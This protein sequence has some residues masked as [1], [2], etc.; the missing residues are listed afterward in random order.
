MCLAAT[1]K[2]IALLMTVKLLSR[3]LPMRYLL[4]LL[5]LIFPAFT[6]AQEL[7]T[8][9][10]GEVAD[11]EKINQN[12]E[13]LNLRLE[14]FESQLNSEEINVDCSNNPK[15]LSEVQDQINSGGSI[16][17]VTL[18]GA[19]DLSYLSIN[20]GRVS[21]SGGRSEGH[22]DEQQAVISQ[23]V[24]SS[25]ALMGVSS[26][27]YL[28]FDCLT[29]QGDYFLLVAS[30][31]GTMVM[32]KGVESVNAETFRVDVMSGGVLYSGYPPKIDSLRA[33]QGT[34]KLR[35]TRQPIDIGGL[36]MNQSN[37]LCEYCN[38]S[39]SITSLSGGSRATYSIADPSKFGSGYVQSPRLFVNNLY[40]KGSI[41]DITTPDYV[42]TNGEPIL[43]EAD[44]YGITAWANSTITI[45][46][47]HGDSE[48]HNIQFANMSLS[49]GSVAVVENCDWP[50]ANSVAFHDSAELYFVRAGGFP[51]SPN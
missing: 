46:P 36:S 6:S 29:F 4:L 22:C 24:G 35:S 32:G 45:D 39:V 41:V 3:E 34:I 49:S 44:F 38:G 48:A 28:F 23:E 40:L 33:D 25:I 12:F 16:F 2:G 10:N 1:S 43:V 7:H 14:S 30:T 27:A 47:L 5:L 21:L 15:A 42:T 17:R 31:N 8:F 51:C 19:C 11:A 37:F 50:F 9:S 26:G 18:K 13:L 20:K